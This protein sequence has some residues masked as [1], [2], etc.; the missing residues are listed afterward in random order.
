MPITVQ[1]LLDPSLHSVPGTTT[2]VFECRHCAHR[3]RPA[4]PEYPAAWCPS[5][6]KVGMAIMHLVTP[7]GELVADDLLREEFRKKLDVH[8]A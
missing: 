6:R 1:T 7:E 4:D 2:I 3:L 8:V 5:C